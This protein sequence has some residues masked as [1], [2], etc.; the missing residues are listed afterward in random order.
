MNNSMKFLINKIDSG[1]RLDIFLSKK[2][3]HFTRSHIKK[4]IEMSNVTI[5]K[6]VITFPSKKN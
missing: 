3:S 5:N 4:I 1:K 6:K 2:I